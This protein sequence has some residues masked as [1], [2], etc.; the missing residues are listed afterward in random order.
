[1]KA[2]NSNDSV[3][4]GLAIG[5]AIAFLIALWLPSLDSFFALDHAPTPNENRAPAKLPTI[6]LSVASLRSLPS[7]LEAYYNDN[8]GF[9]KRLIRWE[10]KWKQS[11]FHDA[12]CVDVLV[13]RDGWL[14]YSGKAMIDDYRGSKL[15]T[16]AELSDWQTLLE[17]RRD[18]LSQRGI[19]YLFVVTPDKQTIYPEHLP[20]WLTRIG[21]QTKLDQF[22]DHMR[23]HST[24]P[25]LD[26]RSALRA[27]KSVLP[28]YQTTDSHWN[29]Y[30]AFIGYNEVMR[31]L[32]EQLPSLTVLTEEAFT[33]AT[34]QR[35]S[36][37]DMSRMLGQESLFPETSWIEMTPRAPLQPLAII[38]DP[39]CN[40]RLDTRV[41]TENPTQSLRLLMFRD[42]FANYWLQYFGHNFLRAV[43]VWQP[44]WDRSL[45]ENEHPD[46]VVDEILE[47]NIYCNNPN[48]LRTRDEQ[49]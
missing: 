5:L 14:Y 30:G 28:T 44:Y 10:R 9:R 18:W 48:R 27:A 38:R 32:S 26:M 41:Y 35:R 4:K 11:W 16:S 22:F 1:M 15:F 13:G 43:Y 34:V 8:F 7:G 6:A 3:S 36:G 12:G 42:S 24:V 39:T 45:I 31:A 33:S 40:A 46:V 20:E 2:P 21:S 47:F 19:K 29:Y 23:I 49:P 37:G 17:Q 25:V